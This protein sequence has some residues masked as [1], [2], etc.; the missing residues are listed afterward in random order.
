MAMA[1]VMPSTPLSGVRISWLMVARK[2]LLA[3][4][5]AS[6]SAL[7]AAISASAASA[8]CLR[9]IR[10]RVAASSWRPVFR[11]SMAALTA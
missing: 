6:A 2:A 1:W 4:F 7:A 8:A 10:S 9:A 11:L 3:A 5:A